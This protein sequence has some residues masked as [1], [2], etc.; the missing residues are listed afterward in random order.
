[1]LTIN[2]LNFID[3]HPGPKT[4]LKGPVRAYKMGTVASQLCPFL[5]PSVAL[6]QTRRAGTEKSESY[7]CRL[8]PTFRSS[9]KILAD[10]F[11]LIFI[12]IR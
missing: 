12:A 5:R 2:S 7:F 3:T 4:G 11:L 8:K 10:V 9:W 6:S 1:M